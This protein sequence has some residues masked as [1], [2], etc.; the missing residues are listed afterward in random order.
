MKILIVEDEKLA[1]EKLERQLLEIEPGFEVLAKID[2]IEDTVK[3]LSVH[4]CDLIFLDIHLADGLSFK[5]FEHIEL[6][7]PIIFTTA[8]DQYAIKAFKLN[9]IDYI[10]KPISKADLQQSLDKLK[11]FQNNSNLEKVDFKSLKESIKAENQDFQKRFI[12]Y[13]ADKIKSILTEEIAYF[14]AENKYVYLV[15]EDNQQYIVDYSL[16]KLESLLNP[17][18]FFRINRQFL[19]HIKAIETMHSYPKGRVKI[20]LK[21]KSRLIPISSVEKSGDFKK[22]LNR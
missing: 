11:R 5:I 9:S 15:T 14:F 8:Y 7:T 19:I 20:D 12:V 22:W 3:W 10:L 4:A 21:P 18:F 2:S 6:D 16:D 1:A 13:A 17:D